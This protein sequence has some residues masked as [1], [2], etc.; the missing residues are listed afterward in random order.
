[1]MKRMMLIFAA[2][3]SFSSTATRAADDHA[4][5][6]GPVMIVSFI[7]T[8]PG[9][10]ED[11][12]RYLDGPYKKLM[13]ES[14]KQ[15]VILDYAVWQARPRDGQDAD[16]VLTITYKNMAAFDGLQDRLDP[17]VKQ[18][19]GSLGQAQSASADREQLRRE[20][21]SVEVRQLILK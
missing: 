8:Q 9:K 17:I 6:F 16:L 15:G 21:G 1:M 7:R 14:K 12:L 4:Y 18:T 3:L 13:E 10:F 2:V 20:A 5:T 11:Y 19:F